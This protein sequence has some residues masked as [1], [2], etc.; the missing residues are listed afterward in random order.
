MDWKPIRSYFLL[1]YDF[2]E[3]TRNT[4][5]IGDSTG[6]QAYA[7]LYGMMMK[8]ADL[9]NIQ[10]IEFDDPNVIDINKKGRQK[11]QCDI[12]KRGLFKNSSSLQESLLCHKLHNATIGTGGSGMHNESDVRGVTGFN[13]NKG[14][15]G[16]FDFVNSVC[17]KGLLDDLGPFSE[18]YFHAYFGSL[19]WSVHSSFTK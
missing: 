4:L 3:N 6:R 19:F 7:T 15:T 14:I 16:K 5:F 2:A 12:P 9:S 1:S 11:E 18:S 10:V 17:Y 13:H 8:G